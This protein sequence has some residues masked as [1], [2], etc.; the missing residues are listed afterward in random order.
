MKPATTLE[1]R[2]ILE[3]APRGCAGR[4]LKHA[5]FQ[6]QVYLKTESPRAGARG[7]D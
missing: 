3:V 5:Q 4:G 6:D 2:A 7:A 1:V